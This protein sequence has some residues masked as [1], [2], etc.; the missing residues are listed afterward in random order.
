MLGVN[1]LYFHKIIALSITIFIVYWL[2]SI[3]NISS[4]QQVILEK[5]TETQPLKELKKSD[6]TKS[7][8]LNKKLNEKFKKTISNKE[9][10]LVFAKV[11]LPELPIKKIDL[12]KK[13][14]NI[15]QL[16]VKTPGQPSPKNQRI[17]PNKKSKKQPIKAVTKVEANESISA[18][19]QQLVSDNSISIELA[20]PNESSARQGLFTFLYQCIGMKFGVLN[21]QKVTL[22]KT[23][24]QNV[25]A[26]DAQQ[27]SEWLRIA[28]GKLA[29]QERLWLQQYNL[30]GTPV[31]LFPKVVDWQLAKLI[32][33]ELNGKPLKNLRAHY[34]YDHQRLM[35]INI[36]LNG[37][38]L[39]KNWTLIESKCSI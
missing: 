2:I 38:W 17:L 14:E 32:N 21:N 20:W 19:Y 26:N 30:S 16:S 31:R 9:N 7:A 10:S 1:A 29:S 15:S 27:S 13:N 24:Y 12:I 3:W 5:T 37:Q 8:L 22:A 35:L 4:W 6:Q 18:I 11:D 23:F 36:R 39:R 28:Q 34:K 33:N 25:N